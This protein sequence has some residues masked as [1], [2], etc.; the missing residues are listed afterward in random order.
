[1]TREVRSSE[2]EGLPKK[3]GATSRRLVSMLGSTDKSQRDKAV[4]K[5]RKLMGRKK[6]SAIAVLKL[7]GGLWECFWLSDK[8]LVQQALAADLADI[9]LQVQPLNAFLFLDGFIQTMMKT[10]IRVDYLRRDKF[11]LLQATFLHRAYKHVAK[12][13]WDKHFAIT[14][15]EILDRNFKKRTE[16]NFVLDVLFHNLDKL[17]DVAVEF[18]P[19]SL[20]VLQILLGPFYNLLLS[21]EPFIVAYTTEMFQ[22]LYDS[23]D[24][25][26][27]PQWDGIIKSATVPSNIQESDNEMSVDEGEFTDDGDNIAA[28][29]GDS[30]DEI[31][32]CHDTSIEDKLSKTAESERENSE[33]P[34]ESPKD[35][36]PALEDKDKLPSG[37][38]DISNE[39]SKFA[40]KVNSTKSSTKVDE[41][42]ESSQKAEKSCTNPADSINNSGKAECATGNEER[43]DK[44]QSFGKAEQSEMVAEESKIDGSKNVAENS[45]V[46]PENE[47]KS[48]EQ[49]PLGKCPHFS[50]WNTPTGVEPPHP[51]EDGAVDP[52]NIKQHMLV[53]SNKFYDLAADETAKIE[54]TYRKNLYRLRKLFDPNDPAT[55]VEYKMRPPSRKWSGRK[56][57]LFGIW[58][59]PRKKYRSHG[60]RG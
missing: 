32:D 3:K 50:L 14:T 6:L 27:V 57:D 41:L 56:K 43:V 26:S 42:N 1:M 2:A 21:N 30:N 55:R 39:V 15:A 33:I 58:N 38:K 8:P 13:D 59:P 25:S 40:G 45:E 7:W 37:A 28:I 35:P 31:D 22:S 5:L 46:G 53:I 60:W 16:P 10:W 23:I 29:S 24:P 9:Q 17:R 36:I 52:F 47:T 20:E 54:P 12:E 4:S 51:E 44:D 18:G 49:S 19:P 34:A 11:I 48:R